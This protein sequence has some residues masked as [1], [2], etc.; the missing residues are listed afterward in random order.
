MKEELKTYLDTLLNNRHVYGCQCDDC[1]TLEMIASTLE[2]RLFLT[3]VYSREQ[4][5]EK[6]MGAGS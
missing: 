1:Q 4:Q 3:R 5:A 6:A 2:T